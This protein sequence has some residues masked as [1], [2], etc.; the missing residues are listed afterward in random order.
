MDSHRQFERA[1]DPVPCFHREL[2]S[3]SKD[4]AAVD[5][6]SSTPVADAGTA[7]T[8]PRIFKLPIA[9]ADATNESFGLNPFGIPIADHGSDGHPGFDFE[10]RPGAPVYVAGDGTVDR[11][12]AH[13]DDPSTFTVQFHHT[14]GGKNYR[15]LYTNVG[16][17]DP[18]IVAGAA[19][20][21]GQLLGVPKARSR[22]QGAGPSST[23]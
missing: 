12:M 14:V 8:G 17:V 4:S 22:V 15:T 6:E 13:V 7:P 3:D 20:T 9:E 16:T 11:V 18:A 1:R 2:R 5:A 10:I 19:V 23:Q 21:K